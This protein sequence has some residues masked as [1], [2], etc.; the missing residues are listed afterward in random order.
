MRRGQIM[1][2]IGYPHLGVLVASKNWRK[3]VCCEEPRFSCPLRTNR[4][5]SVCLLVSYMPLA[6]AGLTA[7]AQQRWLHALA[8][9]SLGS[10]KRRVITR[11][12][13]GQTPSCSRL[14]QPLLP[15]G[16][17]VRFGSRR[18]ARGADDRRKPRWPPRSRSA[19]TILCWKV[20]SMAWGA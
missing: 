17:R 13:R 19:S 2:D 1:A 3:A 14:P 8:D 11:R 18:A 10:C 4:D 12:R 6:K 20:A 7:P 9:A 16:Q 15:A 5:A